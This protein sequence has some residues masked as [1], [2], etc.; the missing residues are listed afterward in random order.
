M[1]YARTVEHQG[2]NTGGTGGTLSVTK[3][4]VGKIEN[5]MLFLLAYVCAYY[6]IF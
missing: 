1:Q 2:H 3:G 4:L 6:L 5:L